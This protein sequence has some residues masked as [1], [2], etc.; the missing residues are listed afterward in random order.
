VSPNKVVGG[1]ILLTATFFGVGLAYVDGQSGYAGLSP[2]FLA[3]VVTLGLAFCGLLILIKSGSVFTDSEDS[4][5]AIATD[6]RFQRLA[7]LIG[8][9]AA[10]L[11]II[12]LLGF[13]IASG[14]LMAI[15]AYAYGNKRAVRNFLIGVAIALPIWV[16]FTQVLGLNLPILP[17]LSLIKP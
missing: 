17:L 1:V 2:R 16:L 12:G 13:V 9:L 7:I 3:T 14:F 8:G 10:H 5:T 6:K 4:G 15:V 11:V